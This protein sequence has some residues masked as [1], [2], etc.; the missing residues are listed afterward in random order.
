MMLNINSLGPLVSDK[1][2]FTFSLYKPMSFDPRAG[3]FLAQGY[4]L[5]KLCRG[6]LVDATYLISRL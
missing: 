4:N 5:K 1:N 6:P 3:P 2:F